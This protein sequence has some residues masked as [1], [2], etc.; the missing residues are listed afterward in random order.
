MAEIIPGGEPV[1]DAE[2]AVIRHLRDHGPA[3][4]VVLHNFELR[5]RDNRKYEI[6]V[7]VITGTEVTLID[8]KG[9]RGR[10]EVAGGRWYPSNRQPFRSPVE[11][12]RAHARALK[13]NLS[14]QGLG[15]VWVDAMVVL[16]APDARLIDSSDGPDADALSVVTGLADLIPELSRPERVRPSFARDI[17]QY[18][19]Q[20]VSALTRTVQRRSGPL[21]F[22]HWAVTESLGE[23][24]EVTEY[25]AR[26]AD[27]PTSSSSMALLRVYHADPLQPED[28]R[29]AERIAISNAYAMLL[30][31]PSHECVVGCLDFFSGEDESQYVLVLED[32][33]ARALYLHLVDPQRALAADARLRIIRDMLRGL[34]HAHANRVLHRALS[35]STVLVTVAGG[36]MLT[37]FDY[38]RPEDPR[39]NSVLDR[40]AKVLDPAYVAP[41]CQDRPQAMSKASDVYAAGV[42]AY[43]VLTGELPFSSTTDQY[44][45]ASALPGGPMEAAGL[46]RFLIDLLRRMCA[47]SPRGRPSAAEALEALA[48]GE[49]SR[50]PRPPRS[51]TDY[52]NLP[53]GFQLT[54]KYTVHRKIGSGSFSAVY[55]VYDNLADVDRAVKIVDR[56]PDSPVER[57]RQEYSILRNLPPHPNVV[58]VEN[59]DYLDGGNVA[60][61]VF[62]YLEGKDVSVLVKDRV[63]GPADAIQLGVDV[64]TGLAFLHSRG[65]YHCDIKPSNL[66][67]TDRGC[68]I[69]DFNVAVVSESSL[70]RAGGSAKYAPPDR[71]RGTAPTTAE[72]ADRD[73]YALGVSI[74][75]VLTGQYPFRSGGPALGEVAA[76][77]RSAPELRDLSDALVNTL[78]QAI[79]PLRGDRYG[80]ATEFLAALQAIGDVHSRPLPEPPSAPLPVPPTPNVNPFVT[81]LQSLYSQSPVSNAGTRGEDAYGTYVPTALDEHLIPDVLD[82]SYRLVIITGN[83]G[84]GKTAFLERLVKAAEARGGQ[85]GAPRANGT[86]VRLVDGR[87]LRT[88]N[89][90]SQDEGERRNDDVLT[91]FFASFAEGAEAAPSETRLIAINT[92]R[93]VDFLEAHRA[94]FTGLREAVRA[95]LAGEPGGGDITVVNLNQRSLVARAGKDSVPVFDH[96]LAQ[97]T[98]DRLWAACQGCDLVRECYAP[99]NARTFSHPSAGPK[100]TRRLRDL[101]R[102][103]HLRGQLHV[104]LRDL[105]SALAY[106]LTSGR[107]CAQIHELYRTRDSGQILDSF[108]FNSWLGSPGAADRLLRLLRELDVAAV[109]DPALDRRLAAFSPAADHG[110]M[111]IDQRGGYDLSLLVTAFEQAQQAEGSA[112][113][114]TGPAAVYLASARRRFYFECVDDDR[115]RAALPF[116]SAERFLDW[117]GEPGQLDARM[118]DLVTAINRGEGLPDQALAGDGLALAIREVP[119][120]TILSYRIFPRESLSLV[121]AGAL[122]SRYVESEPDGLDLLAHG[123]GGQVA[124]LRIRLDL[125]ELLEHQRE[126]YL[127]SVA[128]LQGRYLELLIF[129]NELSATPYQEVVLTSGTGDAHRIRREPDGRLVMTSSASTGSIGPGASATPG[130][131]GE[132]GH[133]D[134]T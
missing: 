72:L 8:V 96:V 93:L 124:R 57:L 99:H 69:I 64:A 14:S 23:T 10:I 118:P 105:R 63:L 132:E 129:K 70:S 61:L 91:S 51:G 112:P 28:V 40:L 67:W 83:A 94:E 107:D 48:E 2:R 98:Q 18:R 3:D 11:K 71:S 37:G 86:D 12:L 74:Y 33:S 120:G 76:D 75:Q 108:Y 50:A 25:R 109:P 34:A 4:W 45:R 100:V 128:D 110:M 123:S 31:L 115:A 6:D 95:A 92:G 38:A 49:A 122:A 53:E 42:V 134:G 73:V 55:Q 119:G 62:E 65:V 104:T 60:Y 79:A 59:A 56:D 133:G 26:N 41:E 13:G 27:A 1:N 111:R 80:S 9:T 21:R 35:P 20:I 130:T 82:G 90:G 47:L 24:E 22:G 39:S 89:D 43:Q 114:E 126:G 54:R 52:R 46:P 15:R 32:V 103:V 7:L 77:P 121:V 97:L 58:A 68:K 102:L 116:R 125:F 78:L 85:R 106:M 113:G 88:N 5:L 16:T 101:L 36:A 30:R 117:L 84:D 127:P 44:Q 87:W 66:L 81:H 17:R 131:D 29:T 19:N